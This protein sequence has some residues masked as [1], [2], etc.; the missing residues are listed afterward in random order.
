MTNEELAKDFRA[1]IKEMQ[2]EYI[3][4][5]LL[6]LK[7]DAKAIVKERL[8][9]HNSMHAWLRSKGVKGRDITIPKIL[10]HRLAWL[11]MLAEEFERK[12]L[13]DTFK[14]AQGLLY[15]GAGKQG[16]KMRYIC[17]AIRAGETTRRQVRNKAMQVVMWRLD[18]ECTLSL[19]LR[20]QGIPIHDQTTLLLQRH[21]KA[22]LEMLVK[23]FSE[24]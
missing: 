7:P 24:G 2:R 18:G 17:H 22:W 3:P 4:T 15:R 8:E 13:A 14:A 20:K 6:P 9:G 19:W 21:R 5:I 1:C 12:T 23:E 16:N 10:A 11:G